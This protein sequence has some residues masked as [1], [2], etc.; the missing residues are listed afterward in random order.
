MHK[1]I[2]TTK[3]FFAR[4]AN[5]ASSC[6][7]PETICSVQA[8]GKM[9]LKNETYGYGSRYSL[10][11]LRSVS[12]SNL[13]QN[14]ALINLAKQKLHIKYGFDKVTYQLSKAYAF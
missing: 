2:K 14:L 6:S 1:E 11:S 3:Y 4:R 5:M 8:Y 7:S 9:F 13:V 10:K 12:Y